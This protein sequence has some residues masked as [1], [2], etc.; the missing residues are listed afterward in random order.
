MSE[1]TEQ[2]NTFSAPIAVADTQLDA[3]IDAIKK[4]WEEGVVGLREDEI[5]SYTKRLKTIK[6]KAGTLQGFVNKFEKLGELR[7]NI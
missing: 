1:H 2:K 3:A 6:T 4:I 5:E 7:K